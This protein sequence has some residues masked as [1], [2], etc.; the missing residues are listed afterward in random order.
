MATAAENASITGH[1]VV[2]L[3]HTMWAICTQEAKE[4]AMAQLLLM[5]VL[6]HSGPRRQVRQRS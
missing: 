5:S 3:P 2:L 4:S 1:V 6:S